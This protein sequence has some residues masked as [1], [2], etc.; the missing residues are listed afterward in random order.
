[1]TNWTNTRDIRTWLPKNTETFANRHGYSYSRTFETNCRPYK[2]HITFEAPGKTV[3]L[4]TT[5]NKSHLGRITITKELLWNHPLTASTY[6][7]IN[8]NLPLDVRPE[9]F[10]PFVNE[11]LNDLLES[12]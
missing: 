12:L 10:F 5:T 9:Q 3:E 4:H 11:Q 6:V 7:T 8:I 1:M 2:E